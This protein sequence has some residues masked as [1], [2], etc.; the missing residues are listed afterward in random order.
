MPWGR[1]DDQHYRH[2]KVA[3]LED[4]LRKGCLAL[5]WLA[6]SWCN[7]RLTDGRVPRGTVRLLGGDIEEADELVRV[8]LWETD[9]AGYRV[10]DFLE[11]NKS[12]E[13]VETERIQRSLAGSAGAHKRWHPDS[14]SSSGSYGGSYGTS[15]NGE[16][17]EPN[18]GEDAPVSRTPSPVTRFP[19]PAPDARDGLTL[20]DEAIAALE[21]RTGRPA[22]QAGH[23]QI[24]EYDRLVADHGLPA[25]L[26]AF[27]AV[28][29][30]QIMTARQLIWPALRVL[31]PFPTGKAVLTAVEDHDRD[32]RD[33]RRS[34]A[35]WARRLE[36][37]QYTGE[38]DEAWGP[39]PDPVAAAGSQTHNGRT[40]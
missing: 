2:E 1:V 36:R 13:Q 18:S 3:E 21:Q 17:D 25:V 27:D 22:S 14:T 26:E 16:P 33:R 5:F 12:R 7:D 15:P 38:W 6:I 31:E 35:I 37:F 9:G 28:S 29:S 4:D 11:F 8:G 23:K 32:K 20:T 24:G 30:G 19:A 40:P 10:H 39:P 34:E